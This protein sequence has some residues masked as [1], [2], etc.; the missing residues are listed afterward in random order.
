MVHLL[1]TSGIINYPQAQFDMVRLGIGLYGFGNDE[2]ETKQ[3][4]NVLSLKSIISTI[5]IEIELGL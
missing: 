1:N 5:K 3:L 2:K 4:K